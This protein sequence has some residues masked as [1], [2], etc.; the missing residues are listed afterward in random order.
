MIFCLHFQRLNRCNLTVECCSA[1]ESALSSDS[2]H[3]RDLDLSDNDLQ[4]SG[5]K[6]PLAGLQKLETLWYALL[7]SKS[8]EN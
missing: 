6:L 4:D 8:E 7:F 3:L 1:L 2:S 5:V